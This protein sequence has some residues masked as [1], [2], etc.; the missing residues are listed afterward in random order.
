MPQVD[1]RLGASPLFALVAI[2]VAVVLASF[3]YRTTLPPIAASRRRILF[4]LRATALALLLVL[5]L[6]P[7]ISIV[8]TSTHPPLLTILID[9]SKSMS[10]TDR[11]GN[12]PAVVRSILADPVFGRLADRAELR[13]V[14]FGTTTQTIPVDSLSAIA[15]TEDG[16]D[17]ASALA[18]QRSGSAA[19]RPNAL[20]VITDGVSTIG[21]NPVHD[22]E[23]SPVP[24]YAIGVGETTE[25]RDVTISHVSANA[26]TY[27]GVET[28]VDVIV[29]STGFPGK[30]VEVA[31]GTQGTV[32]DRQPLQL[33]EGT[34]EYAVTLSY[35]PEGTGIQTYA[36]TVSALPGEL[37]EK[38]NRQTFTARVRK[39]KLRILIVAGA[40]S[41]DVAIVRQTLHEVEQFTV[42][43][44]TQNP[45]GGFYEGTLPQSSADSA[46]CLFLLGFP[47]VA[48]PAAVRDM[49]FASASARRTPAFIQVSR[50][51]DIARMG[52][53]ATL[54]PF[55]TEAATGAEAEVTA[56]ATAA[57]RS[58]PVVTPP[59]GEGGDP[60]AQLPPLFTLRIPVRVHPDATVLAI[61]RPQGS[62]GASPLILTRRVNHQRVLTVLLHGVWR[63]RLM[64]Q[65]SA[66]TERFFQGFLSNAVRWLTASDAEGPVIA[67]PFKESYAQGE[68]LGFRAEVYD[69]GQRPVDDAEVRIVVRQGDQVTEGLLLPRGS[70]RYD[71][72]TP[73]LLADGPAR[74]RVTAVK[75]GVVSGGD[76]GF[77]QVSGTAIEFLNTRMDAEVLEQLAVRTGG[78]FLRPGAAG[79][80][81]SLLSAR[82]SFVPQTSTSSLELHFRNWPWYAAFVVFL[83]AVEWF[84]R[85]R[86]GMI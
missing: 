61:T 59:Y 85:K 72:E 86:S 83:L 69:A 64:A 75:A 39:S 77:V 24:V 65:R 46:D 13:Y 32:L 14:T 58:T 45:S 43:S 31:L 40:P 33:Q 38:N 28:S 15:F 62:S 29:K 35:K 36:V 23:A 21:R 60:W 12:R 71:G 68:P 11:Q 80:L 53:W 79:E 51:T 78:V 4:A 27:S 5:L 3:Y 1:F 56:E 52:P 44:F 18:A 84:L 81:D 63:W 7:V 19:T 16:T 30:K 34:R 9:N 10:I 74:Y 37:T 70:G 41:P 50:S 22:A 26:V 73:G 54:L 6:E 2:G 66:V 76:S 67:R 49:L 17:L 55:S 82:S 8:S 48:T 20:L 42:Q 25:Q 57:E 47:S